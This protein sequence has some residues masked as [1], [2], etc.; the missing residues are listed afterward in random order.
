MLFV[1]GKS[2]SSAYIAPDSVQGIRHHLAGRQKSPA[3]RLCPNYRS[4]AAGQKVS[5]AGQKVAGCSVPAIPQCGISMDRWGRRLA[6]LNEASVSS[7]SA[8]ASLALLS[9]E[10]IACR[11]V[12]HRVIS[13]ARNNRVAFRPKQTSNGGQ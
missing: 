5:A 3:V 1:G 11:L 8:S 13:R 2:V 4:S 12:A 9:S 7:L 10:S 6:G